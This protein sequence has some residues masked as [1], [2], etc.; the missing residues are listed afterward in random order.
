MS[1]AYR[2][3]GQPGI[4]PNHPGIERVVHEQVGQ[5]RGNRR[6]L[7]GSLLPRCQGPV[8]HLHGGG[9]PPLDVEQNPTLVGVVSDRLEEQIMR[10]AVEEGPDIKVQHPVLFPAAPSSHGQRVMGRTPRTVTVAVGV[11]D[12][13]KLLLQQHRRRGLGDSVGHNGH[14][15]HP[16]PRPMILRYLHRPH[17]ARQI[18]ARAHPVPQL[19]EVVPL[20][21]R[22]SVMLTA[23]TPGAPPLAWTF[24]HAS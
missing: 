16:D 13:L 20:R 9:K 15:Q 23:S 19:V 14:P 17:R 24:T 18:A 12:R 4:L 10:D 21:L 3:K 2:S 5:Q 8:G 7:R 1:S 11:E 6:P 22:N